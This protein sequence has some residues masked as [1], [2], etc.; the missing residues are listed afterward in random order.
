MTSSTI[1]NHAA[2]EDE[3]EDDPLPLP[4][5]ISTIAWSHA[6]FDETEPAPPST[7]EDEP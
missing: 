5:R 3:D 7:A 4:S 2:D 1:G 6:A